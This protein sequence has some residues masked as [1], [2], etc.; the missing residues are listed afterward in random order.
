MKSSKKPHEPKTP[1]TVIKAGITFGRLTAIHSVGPDPKGRGDLWEFRCS[2]DGRIVTFPANFVLRKCEP[3]KSCGCLAREHAIRLA[4]ARELSIFEHF[5]QNLDLKNRHLPTVCKGFGRC[6]IWTGTKSIRGRAQ[7][8]TEG[9]TRYATHVAWYLYYG[10]WPKVGESGECLC[11][12]CDNPV[13]VNPFHLIQADAGFNMY[14]YA[15]KKD[16]GVLMESVPFDPLSD[17]MYDEEVDR[18]LQVLSSVADE[19]QKSKA[20]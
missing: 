3:R 8:W 7:V 19:G 5:L 14:D 4:E 10:G 12:T 16:G 1:K 13:C 18:F 2:C 6:L 20:V 11:H 17:G 9:K 15:R